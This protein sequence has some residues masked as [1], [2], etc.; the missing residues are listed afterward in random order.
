MT[1]PQPVVI[2]QLF[3]TTAVLQRAEWSDEFPEAMVVVTRDDV[4]LY[5]L[6]K[7]EIVET[8]KAP[9]DP[10]A[11]TLT[12]EYRLRIEPLIVATAEGTLT[13]TQASN[14]G[15]SNPLKRFKPLPDSPRSHA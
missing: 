14:C 11:S 8:F 2:R 6:F 7:G 1:D 9:Y 4:R 13:V 12:E 5:Q 3:P 15:C 10:L